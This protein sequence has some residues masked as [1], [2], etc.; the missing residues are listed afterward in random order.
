VYKQK[1]TSIPEFMGGFRYAP[2]SVNM[3]QHLVE[4]KVDL[5]SERIFSWRIKFVL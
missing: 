5:G 4:I 3:A 2:Q 1:Q